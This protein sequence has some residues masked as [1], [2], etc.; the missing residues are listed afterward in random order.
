[1]SDGPRRPVLFGFDGY[2]D[3]AAA[4]RAAG[5]L[6]APR[7]ALVAYVWESLAGLLLHTEVDELTGIMSDAASEFDADEAARADD[8]ARAGAELANSVGF[9]AQPVSMRGR[10]KAWPALLQIADEHDVAAIVI[11]S[12]GSGAVRS[13]LFGSV[14]RGLLHRSKRPLLIVPQADHGPDGPVIIA[15][16]GSEHGRRAIEAASELFGSRAA[17]V[18]TVWTSWEAVVGV[19]QIGVPAGMA[20]AGAERMDHDLAAKAEATAGEGAA[21]AAEL[22]MP[23]RA[24]ALRETGNVSHTLVKS[25]R[26]HGA[27][28]IVAGSRGRSAV[29]AALLGSVAAGLAHASPVPLLVVPPR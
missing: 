22:G 14:S 24:E 10:P 25:A 27:A 16:D 5:P 2:D 28:A 4:I 3:A 26:D 17:I 1:M 12:E 13:A 29:S 6:L 11:G 8:V 19:G 21:L 15:Y 23:A 20:A 18:Q 9:E 7:R